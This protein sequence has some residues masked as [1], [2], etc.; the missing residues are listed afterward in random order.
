MATSESVTLKLQ[1]QHDKMTHCLVIRILLVGTIFL[2]GRSGSLPIGSNDDMELAHGQSHSN[3]IEHTKLPPNA[4]SLDIAILSDS[5]DPEEPCDLET[6]SFFGA[7]VSNT[8]FDEA[9]LNMTTFNATAQSINVKLNNTSA[10]K[11]VIILSPDVLETLENYMHVEKEHE[12]MSSKTK[13]TTT[14]A[15]DSAGTDSQFVVRLARALQHVQFFPLVPET[16][17]LNSQEVVEHTFDPVVGSGNQPKGRF[18]KKTTCRP[19]TTTTSPMLTPKVGTTESPFN[20]IMA[21]H[22]KHVNIYIQ[23]LCKIVCI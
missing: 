19:K 20:S 11:Q 12:P 1:K 6:A 18:A 23:F 4:S 21:H 15:V 17:V 22:R 10:A 13:N 5:I 7:A 16:Y 9:G 8:H 14:T 3:E 2:A